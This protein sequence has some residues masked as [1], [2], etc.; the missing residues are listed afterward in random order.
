MLYFYHCLITAAAEAES[1]SMHMSWGAGGTGELA[2]F[3]TRW[4]QDLLN[5]EVRIPSPVPL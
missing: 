1:C 4:I 5:L 3:G 2:G